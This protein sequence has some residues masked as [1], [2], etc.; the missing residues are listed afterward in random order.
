MNISLRSSFVAFL[1]LVSWGSLRAQSDPQIKHALQLIELGNPQQATEEMSRLVQQS[2]KS[3]DAHGAYAMALLANNNLAQAQTEAQAAFDLDRKS[4]LARTARGMVYG[5]QGQVQD[6]LKEFNQALKIDEKDVGTYLALSRYYLSIDSNK[7]AEVTLYKAQAANDKDVRSYIGL[8][9][10]YEKQHINQL[11]IDQFEAAK[12]I[13]SNDLTVLANLAGLYHRTKQY[14]NSINQWIKINRLD[15]TYAPADYE[16]ANLFYLAGRYVDASYWAQRYVQL[17]PNDVNGNW[18]LARA[19]TKNNQFT[20]ALVPLQQASTN[21]SLKALSQLLIAQSYFYSKDFPKAIDAYKNARALSAED[22]EFYGRSLFLSGDTA[23]AIEK[24][25]LSV[26]MNDTTRTPAAKLDA[27]NQLGFMLQATHRNLEAADLYAKI[28]DEQKSPD[29]LIY[30]AQMYNLAGKRDTASQF[31]EKALQKD[32]SSLKAYEGLGTLLLQKD[33][34]SPRMKEVFTKVADL[35]KAK[36]S[37]EDLGIGYWGLGQS[38][39]Y[40]KDFTGAADDFTLA[41]KSFDP[42]SPYLCNTYLTMAVSYHSLKKYPEAIEYYK[43]S[44]VCDPNNET[45]VKNLKNL[46]DFVKSKGKAGA[47]D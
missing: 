24:L 17:R 12:K 26:N 1:L 31:Y 47:T 42:K 19:L 39:Y 6:A 22:E 35:A 37:S 3:A 10:L 33:P 30:A 40:A 5:K 9:E 34:T 15:S 8:A 4:V 32:P 21:D 36:N 11:A 29:Y 2:P 13:D 46:Q 16:I 27:I 14:D 28:A 45:V 41:L 38:A 25:M 18:L 20:Q 23:Q 43:K 7:P 44:L